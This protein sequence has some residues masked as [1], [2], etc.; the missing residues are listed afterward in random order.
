MAESETGAGSRF[1]IELPEDVETAIGAFP[2]DP[3]SADGR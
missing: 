2:Q 3:H 1:V